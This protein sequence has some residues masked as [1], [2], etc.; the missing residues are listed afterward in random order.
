MS[1]GGMNEA[2]QQSL[3]QRTMHRMS[4]HHTSL[5]IGTGIS[6]KLLRLLLVLAIGMELGFIQSANAATLPSL[7]RKDVAPVQA[8]PIAKPRLTSAET[9]SLRDA[10]SDPAPEGSAPLLNAADGVTALAGR[11]LA[12]DGTPLAGVTLRLGQVRTSTNQ[13]GLFLLENVAPGEGVL[14][15]DGRHG[16][17]RDTSEAV[18]HGIYEARIRVEA[19]R[20]TSLPWVS[21]LP[22]IDHAHDVV[23]AAPTAEDA[24][25]RTPAVPG[26]ELRIPKGAVLT[27]IDGEVVRYVGLT[28]VPVNRPPF[29]LPR[30]VNVPIYFTAQP[31][32]A[33]ISG[34]H[35][36]WLGAQVVYPNY[37]DELPKARGLFWRYEPD[38]LGWSPYGMGTVTANGRQVVPD[39]GTRIYALSGAMFNGG[40]GVPPDDGPPPLDPGNDPPGAAPPP[41]LPIGPTPPDQ[42]APV[43]PPK[44]G[45]PPKCCDPV[46]LATGLFVE[47]HMDLHVGGIL[48]LAVT[49]TYRPGDYN[50][51]AFGVGMSLPYSSALHSTN[52]Y[53]VVDLIMP[54]GGLVHY[55]RV[56]N[57]AAP[58]DN[59]F[60]TAHFISNTP[61]VFY[62]SHI[63][64]NGNGWNLTRTDG[65]MLVFGDNAPLQ[66]MQDRF[67]NKITLSYS[68]GNSGNIVQVSS[69]S[70]QHIRF[71]YDGSNR[72]IQAVDNIGRTV[73]Y[74]YDSSGRLSTVTDANGGVTTY[75][76]DSSNR[77]HTI[78]DARGVVIMT[79]TYDANDRLINQVS[80]DGSTYQF[81]YTLD[82][83]GKVTETD[84]TDPRGYVRKVTFNAEGYALTDHFATGTPQEAGW[85]F[86]RDP[87]SNLV[88]SVTDPLGRRT[89]RSYD[90][91]GNVLSS[92]E[93]AGTSNAVT[94][95]YTYDTLNG[96]TSVTDPLGHV[97]TYLRD[98]NGQ[99]V[100]V[101]DPLG[102][103]TSFTHNPQGRV[104][105]AT[106][107]LSHVF[108]FSYGPDSNLTSITD[109]LGRVTKLYADAIGRRIAATDPLGARGKWIHDPINGVQQIIDANGATVTKSYDQIGSV[110]SIT[111]PR[112]GQIVYTY[113]ARALAATRTDAMSAVANVTQRDGMGNVLAAGDR[114]GQAASVTYDPLNRPLTASYADGSTVS[115]TWDLVGRLTQ[116][117]DSAGGTITRSYDGMDRLVSETTPQGTVTY[118][119]DAAGRLLTMQAGSQ[120]QV[121]YSYDNADRLTGI[122]QGSVNVAYGYD[123]AGRRTSATLPGGVSAAY[124]WDAASQ[125]T[126][127]TYSSGATALGS[128]TYGYDLAGYVNTRG[129]SLF[130]SALPAPV[131][132]ASYNLGNRLTSRTAAGVTISPTWDLNGN[133]T[134]DGVQT[135]SWD[136][137]NR[138][139]AITGVASFGYDTFNRRQTVTRGGTVTSFL[140]AGWE[141]VQEQQGGSPSAD[142]LIGFG[143]DERVVRGGSTFLADALGSTVALATSGSVQ[144][145][146]GYDAYGVS[147]V[148]GTA[149]DNPFQY[150]GREN[151]GTGLLNYRNRYYSPTWARFISEDRIGLAGG[152]NVYR[153]ADNNPVSFND[154]SGN[155]GQIALG[156][157]GGAAIGGPI[158][159]AI[160]F[161]GSAALTAAGICYLTDCAGSGSSASPTPA[162]KPQGGCTADNVSC[163][164]RE[165]DLPATKQKPNST[166]V[167]DDGK[168]NGTIRD[169]GPDGRATKDIDFG[170]DHG[171]GDPHA[172]DWDWNKIPPRQPGRAIGPND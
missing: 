157:A 156:T 58:T 169:Y 134:N 45:A 46:D 25:A 147:L 154:P 53:Q 136:A 54:D 109:P 137:R 43:A 63:E 133:L 97:T 50:R 62:R 80:A 84:V 73:S 126:A 36:E 149:S 74:A 171:A 101:T 60:T 148:T 6:A 99:V 33:V 9:P 4:T 112:G 160:G 19:G 76:W 166:Q 75:G 107:P 144:T 85:S 115:W 121:T 55:T 82:G 111:D 146:Y 32:G 40:P 79:N 122:T 150:A 66:S 95:S 59:A 30:N 92:T 52:Q 18:D 86:T 127:I 141:V 94:T 161:V 108:Q 15:I 67:G 105:T 143:T 70:G 158:G 11:V 22:R 125:L 119:Y 21:W 170:H 91:N 2:Y 5:R 87:V 153:Y 1:G 159:A 31:G 106:D 78:T 57:P 41:P 118:T 37:N 96:P 38:G 27:G 113:D 145:S 77:V 17:L 123:I 167:K 135:Y 10:P 61:G 42:P 114:K 165:G 168:G 89:D 142:L 103:T 39:Q 98:G 129:G 172:H 139:T 130:T 162:A 128:L 26:L 35:G 49:R 20:T 120:A 163:N 124:T 131:T 13:D 65:V 90:T 132:S 117:Q 71:S 68:G 16:R 100:S 164:T 7:E 102:N 69:S 56:I 155:V 151:D 110:A 24:V 48:P 93:L 140:Y 64:Y 51:R 14:V 138:L 12:T 104:L 23:L 81:S 29:P 8:T 88:V 3:R 47:Q 116:I 44:K 28:P 34:A 72:I 152:I 83:N